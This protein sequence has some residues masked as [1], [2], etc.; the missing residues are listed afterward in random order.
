MLLRDAALR[1]RLTAAVE[2]ALDASA[3][4]LESA[5]R[6]H[7]IEAHWQIINHAVI[8]GA[9]ALLPDLRRQERRWEDL[10]VVHAELAFLEQT[11]RL[12]R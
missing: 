8:E 7:D 3:D 6:D 1:E 4:V 5:Y 12:C 2:T 10:D 9:A 11:C